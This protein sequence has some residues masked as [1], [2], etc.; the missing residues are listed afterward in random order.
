MGHAHFLHP[1]YPWDTWW[2]KKVTHTRCN[3]GPSRGGTYAGES[4]ETASRSGT[5]QPAPTK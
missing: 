5:G 3:E 2:E 1:D 4:I